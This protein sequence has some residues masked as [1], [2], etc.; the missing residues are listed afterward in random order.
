MTQTAPYTN[1]ELVVVAGVDYFPAYP[2]KQTTWHGDGTMVIEFDG[3]EM[4]NQCDHCHRFDTHQ[5]V[6]YS[7]EDAIE[8]GYLIPAADLHRWP[9]PCPGC[10]Y[11][12]GDG[13]SGCRVTSF[14]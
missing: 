10:S 7:Y 4:V 11:T 9:G 14:R 3:M 6:A 12:A 8:R 5:P 1:S 2:I 13:W